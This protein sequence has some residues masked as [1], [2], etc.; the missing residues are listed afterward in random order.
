[1]EEP[2]Q[3][4]VV[5]LGETEGR[6]AARRRGRKGSRMRHQGEKRGHQVPE[7]ES[8]GSKE[9]CWQQK[10]TVGADQG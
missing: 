3:G 2:D 10:L 8:S 1:M 7:L 9:N 6:G 4:H 5:M